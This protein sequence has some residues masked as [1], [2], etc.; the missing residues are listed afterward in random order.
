[1]DKPGLDRSVEYRWCRVT[2]A[3]LED[4]IVAWLVLSGA[5]GGI[6]SA[7]SAVIIADQDFG[8][9]ALP[10][11]TVRILTWDDEVGVDEDVVL[12]DGD[13]GATWEARGRRTSTVALNG[14]GDGSEAWL[15]RAHA[16][17]RAPSVKLLLDTAGINVREV[18]TLQNLSALLDQGTQTRWQRDLE[19]DYDLVAGDSE[20]VVPLEE[21]AI[22]ST[23]SGLPG[24]RAET[25]T[26]EVV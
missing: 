2:R 18:G 12:D 10:Y 23:Y 6:P 3:A 26:I 8:R 7:D 1:M 20:A 13:D 11:L 21:V 15:V 24:A 14:Y 19:V 17:L 4:A 25:I 16:M 22:A 5:S 9:P